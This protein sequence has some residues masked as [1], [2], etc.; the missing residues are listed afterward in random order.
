ML[1]HAHERRVELSVEQEHAVAF[2]FGCLYVAVL[3]FWVGGI[4]ID[5]V[6]V[7]VGLRGLDEVAIFV[8]GEIFAVDVFE[9]R[10]FGGTVVEVRLR[11]HTIVDEELEV[12]PFG[13]KVLSV[14]LEDR[15]KT[16]AHLLGDIARNLLDIGIALQ[17]A[18]ADIEGNVGRVDNAVQ[19]RKKLRHNIFH[20]VCH[21]H[22]IAI[23]LD[24]VA[25]DFDVVFDAREVEHTGEVE[26]IVHVEVY[27]EEG[28]VGHRIEVAIKLLIVLVVE[29]RRLACPERIGF[30][31]DI[32]FVGLLLLA[33][34]PFGLFAKSNGHGQEAAIF[35]EQAFDFG[36]FKKLFAVFGNVEDDVGSTVGLVYFFHLIG[37]TA[38]ARPAYSRGVAVA[39]CADFH[40]VGHHKR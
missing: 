36:V 23:E 16:V 7:F 12:V 10:V 31:Y 17:V 34:F 25:M 15:L 13:L 28:L 40:F 33:V 1:Q 20:L 37:R 39:A 38:V 35:L 29:C 6:A 8:V 30:A 4:E 18:A 24:F 32:V 14:G 5:D 2:V 19:E 27:P 3:R 11:E 26:G 22:L 21:E 9:Q